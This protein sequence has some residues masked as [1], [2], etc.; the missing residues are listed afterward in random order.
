[1]IFQS[2]YFMFRVAPSVKYD[3]SIS[4]TY[5]PWNMPYH[6]TQVQFSL[7]Y[8]SEW[9][10]LCMAEESLWIN[11]NAIEPAFSENSVAMGTHVHRQ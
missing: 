8:F 10:D 9:A 3:L 11:N 6:T 2:K 5:P 7:L 4:L 1:M